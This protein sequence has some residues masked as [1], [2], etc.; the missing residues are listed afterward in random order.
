MPRKVRS[1]Q[2]F[3][4]KK[5]GEVTPETI[6]EELTELVEKG[7]VKK[8]VN[9]FLDDDGV[10]WT[11]WSCDPIEALGMLEYSRVVILEDTR[12]PMG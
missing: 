2:A 1:L 11:G 9:V 12:E 10:I 4:D 6:L 5:K 8:I 3:R 7:K